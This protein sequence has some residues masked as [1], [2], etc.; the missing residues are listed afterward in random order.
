[1]NRKDLKLFTRPT[2]P[3]R[4]ECE[5][6]DGYDRQ[7]GL[8]Q[9]NLSLDQYGQGTKELKSTNF[10]AYVVIGL[11]VLGNMWHMGYEVIY[12]HE[13]WVKCCACMQ[14]C[15]RLIMVIIAIIVCV[16]LSNIKEAS[17]ANIK[18]LE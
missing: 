8:K 1:M 3:W 5:L 18:T 13:D 14:V 12:K 15:N 2:I 7:F 11:W 17:R 9:F 4:L 10:A 16:R 6:V